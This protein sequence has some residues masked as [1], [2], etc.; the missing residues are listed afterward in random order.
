MNPTLGY[1]MKGVI[2][3]QGESNAGHAYEY[4]TLFPFMIEQW[5]KEWKQGDFPFYWVQLADF[6]P[7]TA[8]P[9]RERLGRAARGPDPDH[10]PLPNTGEAVIIDLG[11]AQDIHPR[12]KQDVATRL[13][14]WALAKDYGLKI[15]LPA[16]RPINRWEGRKQVVLTFD[17]RRAVD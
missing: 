9:Q 15:R 3:Y 7:E 17:T 16:A 14:R 8:E 10:E 12:N 4:R 5:R 1:G 13:A 2:W 11:E 6:M